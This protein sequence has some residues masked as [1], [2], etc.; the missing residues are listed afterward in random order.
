MD[1]KNMDYLE[2][3]DLAQNPSTPVDVLRELAK[4]FAKDEYWAVRLQVALNHNTPEDVL[5]DLAKDV[6]MNLKNM[7]YY[8]KGEL[9][10]RPNTPVDVLRELA[11]DKDYRV[12][13]YVALNP[14]TPVDI[15]RELAKD[16]DGSVRRNVA[17]HP[18]SSI[19]LLVMQ[20]EYE[21][22]FRYPQPAVI[23]ALYANKNLPAFAKRVIETL[24]G[25]MI[26]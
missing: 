9:A 18:K 13:W 20:F 24:F 12:R 14:N 10:E 11:K 25:E 2:K 19:K 5:R 8:D 21:K 4:N 22:S 1:L 15:L 7:D 23:S 17:E 26:T 16:E 6:I 3:W